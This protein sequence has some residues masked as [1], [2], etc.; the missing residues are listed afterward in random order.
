MVV[1]SALGNTVSL[2][3]TARQSAGRV[4]WRFQ[5]DAQFGYL[6]QRPAVGPDGTVVAIDPAG[7]VYALSANGGLKWIFN[8]GGF[9]AGPPSIGADGTVYAAASSTI[10]AISSDGALKWSFTEPAGGQGVIVGPTVGPDGNIY[11]VTDFGGLGAFAL[12]PEGRLLWSNTGNPIFSE[13][14]RSAPR[15]RSGMGRP[16]PVDQISRR[17]PT[18]APRAA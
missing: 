4:K 15:S 13:I 11:A 12:S 3:V 6:L 9:A 18:A 16:M 7:N 2:D 17:R 10:Y 14:G 1:D 8:T 5:V